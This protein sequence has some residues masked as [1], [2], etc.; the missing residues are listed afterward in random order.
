M[1]TT[2][3]PDNRKG[4][5]RIA[6]RLPAR[7]G[8]EAKM[9]GGTVI[10]ISEG[11]MKIESGESFPLNSLITVFVQFP[12][13]SIR[14]RAR[15]MWAGAAAP[16]GAGV[17]GLALTQPDPNLKR[18][19][20]EWVAEVKLAATE[21]EGVSADA[22]AAASAPVTGPE[23]PATAATP[24]MPAPPA[25]SSA[26]PPSPEPRGPIRRRLESR[27]GQS[28]EALLDR[29]SEGWQLTIVQLPRQ[30]GGG[31]PDFQDICPDYAAAEKMLRDF[32]RNR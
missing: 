8:S 32:V 29:T 14:L 21:P 22:P 5:P 19:Y 6:R 27:Q 25:A 18:A 1:T 3:T 15:I 7:F 11:G 20:A 13:H 9:C 2:S 10:D 23:S 17:M 16:G 12:R 28:Y 26:A 24:A 30:F 31:K 4:K